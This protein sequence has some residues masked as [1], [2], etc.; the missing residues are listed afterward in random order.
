MYRCAERE[1][2]FGA[3]RKEARRRSGPASSRSGL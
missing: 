2:A 3:T 1:N